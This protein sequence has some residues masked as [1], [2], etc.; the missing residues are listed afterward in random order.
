MLLGCHLSIADG[1]DKAIDKAQALKIN[2]LQ[3]FSHSAR[4]WRMSP[5]HPDAAR[6]FIERR[7]NSPIKYVVIHTGYLMNL[8][9]P[10]EE[11]Y[12]L[13]IQALRE[14]VKRAG[15]LCIA[16][17]N[18]HIGAHVGAG[19]EYGLKRVAQALNEVLSSP[20]AQAAPEVKLLLENSSGE[21]TELGAR[22]D[23]FALIADNIKDM[24]RIGVCL[25]TC[26]AFSA[27]Y[28][29]TTL[30]GLEE[31][32][33]EVNNYIGLEHLQLIHLNDSKHELG[34]RKDRHE[35]IGQ[36]FIG[37]EGFKLVVNHPKLRDL[38]FILETPKEL[39]EQEKLDSRA[40]LMNL[41]AIRRLREGDYEDLR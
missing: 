2:A 23:E 39:H 4:S 28:D 35:H 14:E 21:G 26:H 13:S 9:S 40:D 36:G 15:E 5:L 27:G 12:R 37:L 3:I 17:V 33:K 30:E 34:S 41:E 19:L 32:L 31:M 18:T 22:L 1:L 8:A 24:S 38:P 25:D 6:R 7:R 29:L 11:L 16:H 20:E 10:K